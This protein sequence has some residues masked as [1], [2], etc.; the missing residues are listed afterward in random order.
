[1]NLIISRSYL[2][3]IKRGYLTEDPSDFNDPNVCDPYINK[4]ISTST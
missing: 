3:G 1:M 2:E 4:T